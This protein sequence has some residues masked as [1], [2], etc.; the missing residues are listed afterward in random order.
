MG[1]CERGVWTSESCFQF[2]WKYA[3]D[4]LRLVPSPG[5][6]LH[7]RVDGDVVF[8]TPSALDPATG[9]TWPRMQRPSWGSV[10]PGLPG[11]WGPSRGLAREAQGT[12]VLTKPRAWSVGFFC[13]LSNAFHFEIVFGPQRR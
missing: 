12:C 11:V 10:T 5:H 3:G 2:M 6:R 13:A 4:L 8:T 9:W 1:C 7:L